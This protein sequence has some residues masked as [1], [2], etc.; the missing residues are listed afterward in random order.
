MI[1]V[2]QQEHRAVNALACCL[3]HLVEQDSGD[4]GVIE[5][6]LLGII[7]ADFDGLAA[8]GI[9]NAIPLDGFHLRYDNRSGDAAENDLAVFVRSV[10]ALAGKCAIVHEAAIGIGDLE[11]HTLQGCFLIRTGQLIDNKGALRLIAEL[12]RHGLTSLDG[13]G[14]RCIVQQIA[15]PCAGFL[16]HQ[17][18]AGDDVC[19]RESTCAVRHIFAVGVTHHR[20]VRSRHHKFHIRKGIMGRAVD[21]LHQQTALGTVAEIELHHILLLAADVDRLRCGVDD[22]AAV[23]GKL[24]DDISAFFQPRHGEAAIGGSLVGA[25]DRTACAGGA[26]EVFHLEY[27]VAD[28]FA[29]DA[30]ILPHDEGR[31]R[32]IF[33]GQHFTGAGLDVDLLRG[34]L[35]GVPCGRL[36]LR[37]L[38]PAVPQTGELELAAFVGIESAKVIDLAAAGIVAGVG[39]MEFRTLQGISRHAVHLFNGQRGLLM[40]FKINGVVAVRVEGGKLRGRVQQIRRRHGFF[41]DFIHAGQQVFQLCLALAVCLDLIDAVT[42]CGADFKHG[43]CDGL[44]GVGVVLVDGQVGAFLVFHG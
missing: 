14:L 13:C 25:D 10:Q 31:K 1:A 9:V 11:Q 24:L 42:V 28:C 37:H 7:G 30:I 36:L 35:D 43:I 20:S 40:V 33:K 2:V 5:P 12:Q 27:G 17:R 19:N 26:A 34:L 18:C 22:M 15:V 4:G 21:L 39:N 44:A 38:V 41:A 6:K 29:G 16:Y 8:G 23:T 32:N 3:V